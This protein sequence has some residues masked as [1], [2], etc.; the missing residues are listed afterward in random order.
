M[1]THPYILSIIMM[2]CAVTGCL[3]DKTG[4][5]KVVKQ[6]LEIYPE[7]QAVDVY[8]LAYQSTMGVVHF[9]GNPE[10]ARDYLI[11]EMSQ[12]PPSN[13]I[14]LIEPL[15]PDGRMVRVNLAPYKAAAGEPEPLFQAM[16]N[17]AEHFQPSKDTLEACLNLLIESAVKGK[18]SPDSGELQAFFDKMR[19]LDFP[20]VHHSDKY[21]ELY[22]PAYRVILKEYMPDL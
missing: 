11:R 3:N 5:D 12:V 9:I 10:K 13:D 17:T 19:E 8:K 22:R 6:H 16:M 7:M 18:I 21:R 2:I 14:P 20:A 4:L 1:K 15:S